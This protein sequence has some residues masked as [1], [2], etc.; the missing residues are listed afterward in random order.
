MNI[1]FWSENVNE[2]DNLEETD[3]D[4]CTDTGLGPCEHILNLRVP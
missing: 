2:R 4:T 3:D 1:W